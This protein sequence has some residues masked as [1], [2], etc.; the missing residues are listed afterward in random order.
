MS[1][2][3]PIAQD[4]LDAFRPY[5]AS[6]ETL[7]AEPDIERYQLLFERIVRLLKVPSP[8]NLALPDPFRNTALNYLSGQPETVAFMNEA[9]N[10]HFMLSDIYDYVLHANSASKFVA[11]R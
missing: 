1:A 4:Y 5:E 8:F 9:R 6:L 11:R 10:R 3:Q 2:S 7:Y